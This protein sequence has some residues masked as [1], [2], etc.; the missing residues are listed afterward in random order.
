MV[1][2]E[3]LKMS[4]DDS[5]SSDDNDADR[6]PQR[7]KKRSNDNEAEHNDSDV[8]ASFWDCFNEIAEETRANIDENIPGKNVIGNELD[9]Y[10][11]TP[12]IQ[13]TG[14]PMAWWSVNLSQYPTM[15]KI[16]KIYMTAP[17]SSIYSE[18]LF[19]EAGNVYESKRNRLLPTN[20]EKLVFIHHN[21]PLVNFKY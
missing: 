17:C 11:Q 15:A 5:S 7:K 9:Y 12:R 3:A 4:C 19:S 8:H 2:L 6:S 21:L 14:D 1:L 13:W 20:T 10:L 18:R 16:A